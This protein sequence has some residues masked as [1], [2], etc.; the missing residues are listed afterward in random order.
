MKLDE[1]KLD[2]A[3]KAGVGH[4]C[5]E[6]CSGWKQGRERGYQDALDGPEV[7]RLVDVLKKVSAHKDTFPIQG[8]RLKR[9]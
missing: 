9:F 3:F 6:T 5:K 8:E 7:K 2:G 1:E 4:P